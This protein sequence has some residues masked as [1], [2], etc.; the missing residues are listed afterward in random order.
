MRTARHI[1]ASMP[2][3]R[4]AWASVSTRPG[5]SRYSPSTSCSSVDGGDVNPLRDAPGPSPVSMTMLTV[6]ASRTPAFSRDAEFG[7][8]SSGETYKGPRALWGRVGSGRAFRFERRDV[9][10]FD[11]SSLRIFAISRRLVLQYAVGS[12]SQKALGSCTATVNLAR[13]SQ[14]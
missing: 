2:H 11:S 14:A 7:N 10:I 13:Q 1:A 5:I 4:S 3:K 8:S 12:P 9:E 6:E